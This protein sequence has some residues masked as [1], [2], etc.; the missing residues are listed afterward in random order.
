LG[1]GGQFRADERLDA[2]LHDW[3]ALNFDV[4]FLKKAGE[5]RV[6]IAADRACAIVELKISE[7]LCP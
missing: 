2:V 1:N 7:D 4:R 6:A 3:V 5:P